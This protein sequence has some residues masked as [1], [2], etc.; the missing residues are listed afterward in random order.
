MSTGQGSLITTTPD[1]QDA[2]RAMCSE[3][4]E[5]MR[6]VLLLPSCWF[7]LHTCRLRRQRVYLFESMFKKRKA[8]HWCDGG[9]KTSPDMYE[10]PWAP[11]HAEPPF[12]FEEFQPHTL[13]RVTHWKQL[14]YSFLYRRYYKRHYTVI[15]HITDQCPKNIN[16]FSL[17]LLYSSMYTY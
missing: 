10:Y 12:I 16:A 6:R 9:G 11:H 8:M 14:C 15:Y 13:C 2:H 7:Q 1:T 17:Y 5:N 4:Q 3:L